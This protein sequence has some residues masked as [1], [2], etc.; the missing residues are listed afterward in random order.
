MIDRFER[1]AVTHETDLGLGFADPAKGFGAVTVKL[2]A[3]EPDPI[4]RH[5]FA[6]ARA[7]VDGHK[8]PAPMSPMEATVDPPSRG[9]DWMPITP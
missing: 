3:I 1:I 4:A 6:R 7:P 2:D 5:A 8:P 9:P